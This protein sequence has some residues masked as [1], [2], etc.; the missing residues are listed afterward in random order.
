VAQR[1]VAPV[2]PDVGI[3]DLIRR[4]T[5]DSRRLV[6]DEVRLAKLEIR[7]NLRTG[8]R[9]VMWLSLS[10]GIGVIAL[11]A[12]TIVLVDLL[13]R[14]IGHVWAGALITGAV[15][16]LIGYLLISRGLK[17]LAHPSWT[18]DESRESFKDTIVWARHPTNSA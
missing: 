4:L 15:E 10:L 18:L 16:L 13:G 14:L 17:R 8:V 9:G 1:S 12:L 5:D 7:E 2:D 11:S 3:P 6:T